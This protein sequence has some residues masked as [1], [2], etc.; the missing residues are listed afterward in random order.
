MHIK[1]KFTYILA[2]LFWFACKDELDRFPETGMLAD[3]YYTT[4]GNVEATV[5]ATYNELQALYDY[6]MI[7]WGEMP[8]DNA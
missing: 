7:L 1:Q 8:S 6:Y 3:N 4:Q 2:L 5:T